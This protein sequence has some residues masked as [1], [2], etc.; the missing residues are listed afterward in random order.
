MLHHVLALAFALAPGLPE[1]L[2]K[3]GLLEPAPDIDAVALLFGGSPTHRNVLSSSPWYD[4]A[5]ELDEKVL[6]PLSAGFRTI[7]VFVAPHETEDN[8]S[9]WKDE[10]GC[11]HNNGTRAAPVNSTWAHFFADTGRVKRGVHEQP[12]CGVQFGR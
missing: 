4:F 11:D 2:P 6:A 8:C 1:L 5:H 12:A 7:G 10:E 3:S 9:R